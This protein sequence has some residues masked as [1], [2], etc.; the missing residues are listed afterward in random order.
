MADNDLEYFIRQD[1]YELIQSDG[2]RDP[3]VTTWVY[4]D[5][6]N[7]GNFEQDIFEPLQEVYDEDGVT[8]LTQ[9]Y[10]GS[11][12]MYWDHSFGKMIIATSLPGEQNGDDPQTVSDFATT[13]L[14]DCVAKGSNEF[15]FAFSSHGGGF[16]GFGGDENTG[17]RLT[18]LNQDIASAI[19]EA[20]ASVDGAPDQLDVLG[21][22]A[23][24]M[25]AVGAVDDYKDITKYFL[26]SE[27]VEPGH[28]MYTFERV[29]PFD[30]QSVTFPKLLL[31]PPSHRMGL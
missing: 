22:D 16:S 28:G 15:F 6:R 2:I 14:T 23:C 4:F 29:T 20:L 11:R 21:F 31:A 17:R 9:K 10:E 7:Y 13:A 19:A 18:Q 30:T 5:G 3:T 25:Q 27:A 26:A 12:Y 1:N 8:P 24:L